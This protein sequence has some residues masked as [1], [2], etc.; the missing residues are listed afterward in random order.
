MTSIIE[1]QEKRPAA[2]D[3]IEV[4]PGVLRAQLP[5]NLPGLGHVNCYLLED[6][7]GFAVVDPGMPD[8][9]S[10]EALSHRLAQVGATPER[11]HTVLVTH[12]HPDHFGG[13]GRLRNV[14]GADIVAHQY[15]RTLFD[16]SDD[17]TMDLLDVRAPIVDPEGFDPADFARYLFGDEEIP[18]LP[19][20]RTPWGGEM[21][22]P[23]KVEIEFMRSWDDDTKRGFLTPTPTRRIA[24]G[25]VVTLG[26]REWVTIHTP[27]HTGDHVCLLDPVEGTLLSGDHV[28]PTITPHI[29]GLSY[30]EDSLAEFFAALEL[31]GSLQG[32]STV[33]PAHGDPFVDVAGRTAA[34][35]EHH[36]ERLDL[37]REIGEQIGEA[38]VVEFSHQLFQERSWGSMAESETYAHLEHL[39]IAG[40]ARRRT[41]EGVYLYDIEP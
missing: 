32:V 11:I 16:P 10:Y 37:L 2:E 1:R 24:D 33:L 17:D 30:S 36:E 6:G 26:R 41:H 31:V 5:I 7:D 15:F 25:E 9:A 18:D 22:F 8:P 12:S 14:A 21:P 39:R 19:A 40:R 28:L 34:I 23:P 29:S 3:V 38:G 35:R 20:R 13:A 4:A 27:G